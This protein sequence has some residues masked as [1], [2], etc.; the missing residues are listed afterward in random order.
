M[1]DCNKKTIGTDLLILY[2]FQLLF[3]VSSHKIQITYSDKQTN[4][5]VCLT[6]E[7]TLIIFITNIFEKM[8]CYYYLILK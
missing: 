6:Y 7:L 3:F 8:Y 2:S 1:F 5:D 4:C